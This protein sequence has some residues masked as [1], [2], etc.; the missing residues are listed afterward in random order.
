MTP[1]G[2]MC[3]R[4]MCGRKMAPPACGSSGGAS[5]GSSGGTSHGGSGGGE[6]RVRVLVVIATHDAAGRLRCRAAWVT[7]CVP[8][9]LHVLPQGCA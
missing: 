6:G 9:L 2:R 5:R 1:G 7:Q 8:R 3:G 4:K